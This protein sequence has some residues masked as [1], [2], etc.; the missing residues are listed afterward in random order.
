MKAPFLIGRLIFGGF[1]I[2][3][4]INH[5][6]NRH[7]LSQYVAGKKVPKPEL[8]V[9]ATGVMLIAGGTSIVLGV[10]PKIGAAALLAFLLG[11]SP[12]MHDF[13]NAEDPNQRMADMI[14]FAKN[15]ALAG[16]ALALMG[17]EEPWPASVPLA[18]PTKLQRIK[19]LTRRTCWAA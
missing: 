10:Q 9:T 5:L 14:N 11:V 1:F 6:K 13:W 15:M 3:N 12:A 19:R 17:V 18:Q 2:Y 7:Q 4:G 16:A 8:A